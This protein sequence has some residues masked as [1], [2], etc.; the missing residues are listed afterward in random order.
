MQKLIDIL[1][2][3]VEWVALAIGG[4]FLLLMVFLY[5]F[6]SPVS[7]TVGGRSVH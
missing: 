4:A 1:E 6:G 7:A 3:Y 5:V 2:G